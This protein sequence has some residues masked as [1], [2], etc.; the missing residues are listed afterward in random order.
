MLEKG[1]NRRV[2]YPDY[3]ERSVFECIVNALVHRDYID[4]IEDY[5]RAK[6]NISKNLLSIKRFS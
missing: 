6:K 2:E 5:E 3:P 1:P 4:F